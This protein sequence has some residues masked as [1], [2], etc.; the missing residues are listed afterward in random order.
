MTL[1]ALS[2]SAWSAMF[3]DMLTSLQFALR[4]VTVF[5]LPFLLA[6]PLRLHASTTD[7]LIDLAGFDF[8]VKV[9]R[10]LEK[11]GDSVATRT[12]RAHRYFRQLIGG[13][14][15]ITVY[16]LSPEDWESQKVGVTYG[17][18][19][20]DTGKL[21]IAGM[22]NDLWKRAIQLVAEHLPEQMPALEKMYSLGG[23]NFDLGSFYELIALHEL[24]HAFEQQGGLNFPRHWMSEL[25]ANQCLHTYLATQEPTGLP[26]LTTFPE[27]FHNLPT[28]LFSP[29]GLPAFETL[30]PNLPDLTYLWY[31]TRLHVD[32]KQIFD[33]RGESAL[34]GLAKQFKEPKPDVSDEE[35]SEILT[36]SVSPTAGK[37]IPTWP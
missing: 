4:R 7:S 29:T 30:Y 35:L 34:I 15:K 14:P 16:V 10:G 28:S 13:N 11:K 12:Q 23:A 3:L 9:S 8:P 26:T 27:I 22:P 20:Y 33:E 6:L 5:F 1:E 24:G 17:L 21:F 37:I 36:N 2:E 25:F 19:V 32:A 18:A 31:Q